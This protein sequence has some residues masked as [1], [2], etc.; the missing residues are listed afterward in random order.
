M[1]KRFDVFLVVFCVCLPLFILLFSCKTNLSFGEY[2]EQQQDTINFLQNEQDLQRNY[3]SQEV[4][5]LEDVKKIMGEFNYLFFI[6]FLILVGIIAAYKIKKEA[7]DSLFLYG[8]FATIGTVI[9]LTVFSF[10]DFN[11]IFTQ[12]HIIFFPQGNWTF[13]TDSLIIQTFPTT[14]FVQFARKTFIWSFSVGL[15]MIFIGF[16]LRERKRK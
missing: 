8:G 14:F 5:H 1:K 9:C 7:L 16:A 6:L 3:T 11:A 10:I 12:F 2:T 13:A 4:S 15:I